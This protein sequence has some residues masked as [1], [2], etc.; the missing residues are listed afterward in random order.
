MKKIGN[1]I[2]KGLKTIWFMIPKY[3]LII[4][5][6]AF[7][8]GYITKWITHDPYLTQ[9]VGAIIGFG[10]LLCVILYVLF[11]NIIRWIKKKNKHENKN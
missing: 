7:G 8:G 10:L 5:I 4:L 6:L 9:L 3:L 2:L 11:R 1:W